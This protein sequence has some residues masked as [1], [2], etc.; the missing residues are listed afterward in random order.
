MGK[1]IASVEWSAFEGPFGDCR[2]A[3]TSKGVC[4]LSIRGPEGRFLEQF[5]GQPGLEIRKASDCLPEG[6]CQILQYFSGKRAEFDLPLDLFLGTAFQQQVWQTLRRIP[7]GETRSYRWLAEQIGRP[8]AFR[9]VGQANGANPIPVLVP[10]HRVICADGSMG[11]FS[12]GLD[13][14][15]RLLALEGVKL[16]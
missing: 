8:T 10:C 2:L 9:A 4:A 3:C 12:A 13:L 11:G 1:H 15:R 5:A 16:D 7:Y 14:K 6:R